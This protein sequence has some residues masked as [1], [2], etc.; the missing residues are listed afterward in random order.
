[1]SIDL[2]EKIVSLCKRRGYIYPSSEIYG[3]INSCWD[4]G[5]LGVELKRNIKDF[6][7][8]SMTYFR[9]DMEGLDASII[10]HPDV[11][12]ASGHI[13]GFTDEMVDCKNC[14]LR[15]R[16]DEAVG[17]SCPKCG[18]ELTSARVFNLMFKTHIGPVE[19]NANVIYLRPETAQGIYVNF[20]NVL[21]T[22]RKKVPFGI[23]QIGK[24]FRNEVTPGNF[25]FRMR[26][27]E[28]MEMQYFVQPESAGEWLDTWRKE[29]MQWYVDLGIKA[30]KLRFHE[31]T[32]DELPHYASRAYD[33]E[34]E[35]PFGWKEIE[36]IHSRTDYDLKNHA[37]LSGKD[38]EYFDDSTGKRFVP[39]IVE[40]SAGVDRTLLTCLVDAFDEEK[41]RVVLRLLPGI[42]PVK[43]GIFPLVKR[44]GMPEIAR[45]ITKQLCGHMKVFYDEGGSIGRRYRR[46]DEVGTPF[47][48]TVDAQ[49]LQDGTV[50]VRSRDDMKQ[51]RVEK[52]KLLEKLE[53]KS[54]LTP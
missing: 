30:E 3:G 37:R 27:F 53:H 20:Q 10:M 43:A 51:I 25:I 11:W 42:A 24:A 50:T 14:K 19:D 29:R 36:G 16:T 12:K 2:M 18:G 23:A 15:F 49:T 21:N 40:T 33:I 52:G 35:F 9:D 44:D 48:I 6:W 5:P 39:Y 7:W 26:E 47:G 46:Q 41:D 34:Y 54:P 8:K 13:D 32:K 17:E 1:M 45:E 4:Y 22:S 31:H 38:L 28:Q